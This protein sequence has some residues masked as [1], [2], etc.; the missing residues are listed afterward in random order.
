MELYKILTEVIDLRSFSNL[1]YWIMLAVIWSCSSHWVLGIPF[2]MIMRA[3]RE[4]GV[5]LADLGQVA[6]INSR[7]FLQISRTAAVPMFF[8]L[9]F[10][11]TGLAVLS[12]Y[13][14]VEFAQALF[15][16]TIWFLPVG[17][18]TLRLALVIEAERGGSQEQGPL[19]DTRLCNGLLWLRRKV[20]VIG[21]FA[22][23][24]T[25]MFGMWRNLSHSILY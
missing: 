9:S 25:A 10:F 6:E 21:M 7:R 23:L 4:G 13:Y 12:F 16:L 24:V 14:W 2:D 18:L 19:C 8:F 15:L 22:I 11:F 20:Q 1:W 5:A 17:W 3:K